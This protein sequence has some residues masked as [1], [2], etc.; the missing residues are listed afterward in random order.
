MQR[1][2]NHGAYFMIILTYLLT[3]TASLKTL[4]LVILPIMIL[5][6]LTVDLTYS[7]MLARKLSKLDLVLMGVNAIPY[8]FLFRP[9]LLIPA[10]IFLLSIILSYSKVNVVPQVLGTLGLSSLLL[11][12]ISIVRGISLLDVSVYLI[13]C[14]YTLVEALY[15]EYKLP[16][17]KLGARAVKIGWLTSIAINALFVPFF[18]PVALTLIEPS[19]RFLRP[20]NKLSSATEI[21][22]LGKKGSK[23]TGLLFTLLLIILLIYQFKP[24]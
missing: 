11:P 6:A 3:V 22:E 24:L 14:S 15:V 7:K 13:W 17:R 9:L 18:P 5:H 19:V 10:S 20:G 1:T 2:R 16:F 8:V 4:V 21:K 12:W 23:R